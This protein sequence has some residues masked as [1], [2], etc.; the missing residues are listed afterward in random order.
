[1]CAAWQPLP[2]D[3]PVK[4]G[5]SEELCTAIFFVCLFR[6]VDAPVLDEQQQKQQ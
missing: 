3:L 6:A 2:K 4:R 1:M 5:A